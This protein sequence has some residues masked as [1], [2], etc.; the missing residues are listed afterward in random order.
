MGEKG[1]VDFMDLDGIKGTGDYYKIDT[2]L[3]L[4]SCFSVSI[5]VMA[6]SFT[7][8]NRKIKFIVHHIKLKF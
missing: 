1:K 5:S 7:T 6:Y 2:E 4:I 8:L 3:E